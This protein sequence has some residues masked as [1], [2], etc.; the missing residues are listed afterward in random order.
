MSL[1]ERCTRSVSTRRQADSADGT[2]PPGQ[3]R[4]PGQRRR[5][6]AAP[7]RQVLRLPRRRARRGL[8][9]GRSAAARRARRRGRRLHPHLCAPSPLRLG[10]SC[11]SCRGLRLGASGSI[12][13]QPRTPADP[14]RTCI[15]ADVTGPAADTRC[16]VCAQ[17]IG[18]PP[19][20]SWPGSPTRTWSTTP[21]PL[22]DC[23]PT[24][25]WYDAASSI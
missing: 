11:V 25:A 5:R 20:G 3:R 16:C 12:A 2:V 8:C 6:H 19:L 1:L 21:P 7:R 15:A 23:Q 10:R 9:S 13:A 22:R 14:L 17:A 24:T 18:M 4:V